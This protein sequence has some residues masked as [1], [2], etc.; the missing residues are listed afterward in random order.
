M[1]SLPTEPFLSIIGGGLVAAVLTILFNMWWDRKKQAIAEDWEFKR[2]QA[3]LIH[4]STA[5]L[6]EA[7]FS[8]KA[9]LDY[10]TGM[11]Q[12]L[13][14]TLDQLAVAADTIVRQQGGPDL[15]VA[16]L[17][18]RKAA[19]LQPFRNYNQQQVDLRWNQYEQKVK[20]LDAKAEVHL[21]TLKP[22]VPA[23]LYA[24]LGGLYERLSAPFVWDLPH[25][26]EKLREFQEA[27]P[28][29]VALRENLMRQL[30][31]KLGRKAFL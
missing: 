22:L 1:N 30:E 3:N 28:E 10:L 23:G 13:L 16:E 9:E 12:T 19:L 4:F 26:R 24:E 15:T 17:E 7:F 20:D 29:V 2:Y 11:L 8:G 6:M 27:L 21:T 5:G 25:G 14:S 31:M 18:Q